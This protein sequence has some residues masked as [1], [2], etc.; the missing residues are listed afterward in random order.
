MN[1][2]LACRNSIPAVPL[3]IAAPESGHKTTVHF[4][5]SRSRGT[6]KK[7]MRLL[8][9]PY[10]QLPRVPISSG[11]RTLCISIQPSN[12]RAQYTHCPASV[13]SL[14]STSI[15]NHA[16]PSHLRNFLRNL[17]YDNTAFV[18]L[19]HETP[20][21]KQVSEYLICIGL[22]SQ[23][24]A[25]IN[26]RST[27]RIR[28]FAKFIY[29]GIPASIALSNQSAGLTSLECVMPGLGCAWRGRT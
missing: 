14:E 7:A 22:K 20:I 15:P 21:S 24:T 26:T 16:N 17:S 29:P 27:L 8:T 28:E 3:V 6:H 4:Q 12:P 10:M 18:A 19:S 5:A 25:C 23:L 1:C 11:L 13:S 2:E 9:E